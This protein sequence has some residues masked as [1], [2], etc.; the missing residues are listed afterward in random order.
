M[1][2]FAFSTGV[3]LMAGCHGR[4]SEEGEGGYDV[5]VMVCVTRMADLRNPQLICVDEYLGDSLGPEND[6]A[7][8]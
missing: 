7:F 2:V 4:V 6:T 3:V 1:S 5:R 8:L